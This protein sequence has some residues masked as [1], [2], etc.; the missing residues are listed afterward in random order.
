MLDEGHSRGKV[1]NRKNPT[2]SIVR[3]G[4]LMGMPAVLRELGIDPD[5]IFASAGLT[6]AQFEDPDTELLYAPGSQLLAR[7]VAAAGCEHFGLLIGMRAGASCLGLPGFLLSSAPD[8]GTGLRDLVDNLD[9]HD[10]GGVATLQISGDVAL[11]GYAIHQ[12]SV[13]AAEY[14]YDVSMAQVCN[15]LRGLCG[16]LWKPTEVLLSR[17]PPQNLAI[18]RRFYRAPLHFNADRNAISFPTRWL[19]HKVPCANALLHRYLAQKVR[20][21]HNLRTTDIVTELRGQMRKSLLSGEFGIGDIARRLHLHE[22]TLHR[23]LR[24][25]G[26]S[27][28][29][30]LEDIRYE[31]A[32]QLL[33]D[34]TMPVSK[35]ARTLK[36]ANLGGFN[37]AF[38]RW[39]G[40]TPGEWRA[41]NATE[42]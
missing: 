31:L 17:R 22:R 34:S 16:E 13:E 35:V 30:E 19:E 25:Q 9:L 5:P 2:S 4:P 8:V 1:Q 36:Y 26:T 3:V 38:K 11:L 29:R 21:L 32:K 7:C 18:Y 37:R 42:Q 12:T 33:A 39:A 10:Q 27:F 6:S 14:I 41:R 24:D 20:D 15:I 23:R 40:I 28:R